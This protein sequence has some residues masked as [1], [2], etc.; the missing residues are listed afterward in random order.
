MFSS[1]VSGK[2]FRC[3]AIL[4]FLAL[5]GGSFLLGQ[6]TTATVLGTV[7]DQSGAVLPGVAV[8][9]RNVETGIARTTT[10]GSRGE[11]Q[12]PSLPPGAY[13]VQAVL[14][15]FQTGIRRGITLSVGQ[16]ATVNFDLEVGN[17]SETVEVQAEAPM[18]DTT[19]ATVGGVVDSQQM[20]E[21]PLNARSFLELVPLQAGAIFSE[22]A[23]MS[24][25][26]G[27]G[28][29]LTIVGTR[30]TANSF[31]LDG[32]DMNDAAQ[33]AGDA[34]GS[35]AG[36]ET[37]REFRVITNAYDAEYGRHTGGVISA[38]TKS[39]TNNFHGSL[40]EFLR[41]EKLDAP[42]W[43]TNA[44]AGGIKPPFRRNQFGFSAGGPIRRDKT[45]F[46]GSYEALRENLGLTKTYSV[47]GVAMRN[48]FLGG[49]N[50]GVDPKVKPFLDSYPLPTTPDKSDGTAQW[51]GAYSRPISDNFGTARI[52]HLFS[53]S[54]SMFGR[55][56]INNSNRTIGGGTSFNTNEGDS[57]ASRFA[58]VEETHIF[59]PSLLARTLLSFNRTNIAILDLPAPGFTFPRTSFTPVTN[60]IGNF[61]VSGLASWG[62]GST[63]PKDNIQNVYQFKED[64]YWTRGRHSL[65]MGGQFER[66][67]VNQLSDARSAGTFTFPAL[68]DFLTDT[69][70]DAT[71]V[72]PGSDVIRGYRESLL[73]LYL[74]DD[75]SV[76]SRFKFNL[77]VR[78]EIISTPTEVNGKMANIRNITE[79]YRYNISTPDNTDIGSPWLL[80]PSLKNFAPRVGFAWDV[81][82]N[83]KTSIRGGFG[84]FPDQILPQNL[85]TW[86]VRLPPFFANSFVQSTEGTNVIRIDFPNA[87]ATQ[88]GLISGASPGGR[89]RAEG[90]QWNLNQPMVLK[91]SF[92]IQRELVRN[93]SVDIG[94]S[95]TRGYHLLRGPI[96]LNSTP[97]EMRAY[98]GGGQRLFV[99]TGLPLPNR[100]WSWMR[101]GLSDSTSSYHGLLLTVN[102]RFSHGLQ[103]QTS[104]TYSKSTDDSSSWSGTNDFQSDYVCYSTTKCHALSAFDFR[105]N[106]STN[107]VYALPGNKLTGP[108]GVL[109]G[110]WQLSGILRLNS[111]SPLNP[112]ADLPRPRI[113]NSNTA[114]TNIFGSSVELVPGGNNNPVNAQNPNKYFDVKQFSPLVV[115]SGT[116]PSANQGGYFYGNVGRNVLI[117]PGVA[118]LDVTFTKD[119]KVRWLGEG[120]GIQFRT[121]LYNLLNRPNFGNPSS[122]NPYNNIFSNTGALKA[123]AGQITTTKISSRQLQFALKILF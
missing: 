62:G 19:S 89:T 85:I 88:P 92:G 31:L 21:I 120:G 112:I 90:M 56:T 51:S 34:N 57:T 67:Q 52:D 77:G 83:G 105:H 18:I 68:T 79:N 24:A 7:H 15:G 80:N 28:K 110:G 27:F 97:A 22:N 84:M 70:S 35:M 50:I 46:F 69:P 11:Y 5:A 43:E 74:Q 41:N 106:F 4:C 2:L 121:E 119:T 26:K 108:A 39:G 42:A 30:Y 9:V 95:G 20:R 16:D 98:P 59:S 45:F 10:T 99:E 103:M 6:G 101:W 1:M 87:F 61:T 29:K 8:T 104:Y 73:G 117:S 37:V 53:E 81:A 114:A 78:Y 113:N 107:F 66:F 109:L 32:A 58:T 72:R 96:H 111:G 116:F 13:E 94:Y 33:G 63:N 49:R 64:F 118:N 47:P 82:G 17:V 40:F 48:G 122:T 55:F 36:V 23:D 115:V 123:T 76:T 60:A 14:T 44:F 91:W 75:I 102:K 86:G 93:L 71:F 3:G 12:L 65:K 100:Y 25:T 38:V 54:D